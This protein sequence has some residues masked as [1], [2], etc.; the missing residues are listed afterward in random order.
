MEADMASEAASGHSNRGSRSASG[1]SNS[2]RSSEELQAQIET[3][4]QDLASISTTLSDLIRSGIREGRSKAEQ[5]ASEYRQHGMEQAEAAL[6]EA[7][8]YG[9]ALESKIVQNPFAAVLVALGLGFLVGLM[10]RR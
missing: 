5:K 2:A 3:L 7:R 1:Q 9:D 10:S 6:E 4:K 8:A